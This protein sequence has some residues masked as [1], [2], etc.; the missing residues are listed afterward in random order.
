MSFKSR[1]AAA[2][3]LLATLTACAAPSASAP[4]PSSETPSAT[5]SAS[6]GSPEATTSAAPAPSTSMPSTAPGSKT[7]QGSPKPGAEPWPPVLILGDILEAG[8]TKVQSGKVTLTLPSGFAQT[9][10][11]TYTS[12]WP[13][14]KGPATITITQAPSA[15]YALTDLTGQ[16]KWA[17]KAPVDIPNATSAAI[18]DSVTGG[19]QTW[20]LVVVDSSG[21]ATMMN[22]S[23]APQDFDDY[24]L[25]QSVCSV[26]VTA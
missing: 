22:F 1:A 21:T 19:V 25:Y 9:G 8:T 11:G 18:G 5:A 13:G 4:A 17:R 10:D 2:A 26:Q 6:S 3:L 24:L 7:P 15:G 12:S 20:G 16:Q 14:T 23:S